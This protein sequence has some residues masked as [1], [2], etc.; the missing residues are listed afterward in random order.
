MLPAKAGPEKIASIV[1]GITVFGFFAHYRTFAEYPLGVLSILGNQMSM[2][3]S[4]QSDPHVEFDRHGRRRDTSS[5]S[6]G[7]DVG[8]ASKGHA[9]DREVMSTIVFS[10]PIKTKANST[11]PASIRAAAEALDAIHSLPPDRQTARRWR[12]VT[13]AL[14]AAAAKPA[15]ASLTEAAAITLRAALLEE[16]WLN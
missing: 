8:D 12:N 10:A 4:K 6:S 5:N 1:T 13:S 2:Q 15:D 3:P 7:V 11:F 16:G 9:V 14:L